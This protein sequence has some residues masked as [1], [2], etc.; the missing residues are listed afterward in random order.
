LRF[1]CF[2][3]VDGLF[4]RQL[5]AAADVLLGNTTHSRCVISSVVLSG[6]YRR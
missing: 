1:Y 5:D 2:G 4:A 3:C 6:I